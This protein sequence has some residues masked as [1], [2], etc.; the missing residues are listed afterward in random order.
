MTTHL[1]IGVTGHRPAALG[2]TD[3]ELVRDRIA[4]VFAALDAAALEAAGAPVAITLIS[5][6]ADGADRIAAACARERGWAL[7]AVLPFARAEYEFDFPVKDALA[8]FHLDLATAERVF[9]LAGERGDARGEGRAYE[10]AGRVLLAQSDLLVG[11]WN[12]GLAGGPGGTAQVMAEAVV[13]G[14]PVIHIPLVA[15]DP[16]EVLWSGL[17]DHALGEDSLDTVARAGL[18]RLGTV[19]RRLPGIDPGAAEEVVRGPQRVWLEAPLAAPYRALLWL[20]RAC[21]RRAADPVAVPDGGAPALPSPLA[22]QLAERFAQADHTA[23]AAAGAYRGAYVA[24]FALAAAAVLLSLVGLVLPPGAKPLLLGGEIALIAAILTVTG[25]GTRLGWHRA[26][27]EHRQL[28]ERLRC[29]GIAAKLGDLCLRGHGAGT[30]SAVQ[31]QTCQAARALGLPT[32]EMNAAWLAD[33]RG[34][35]LA[36]TADQ[37]HYFAREATTMHRLDHRLHR[38]GVV[39]FTATALVCVAFLALEAWLGLARTGLAGTGMAGHAGAETEEWVHGLAKWVT[40][41]TAA[42]PT[43]GAALHGIRMQGDFAGAA[44]RSHAMDAQLAGLERA[45]HDEPADYDTLLVRMRRVMALLT[46]DL[47]SWTYTYQGRP[48]V[49][50]G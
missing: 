27:I 25:L 33:V 14:I 49:L 50:P 34:E 8:G 43:V 23:S 28:A 21:V 42:F 2:K 40:L 22:P 41:L 47:D 30:R 5:C 26:W 48:L 13:A 19:L 37:R 15:T 29:L 39:L 9:A 17:N 32:A 44:E 46:E 7:D 3:L 12:G 38:A 24:N 6:C 11:L 18:D 31:A 45:I 35:L 10:R 36:L 1:R 16:A 4:E 20:T